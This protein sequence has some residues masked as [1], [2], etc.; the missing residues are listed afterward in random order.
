MVSLSAGVVE[1]AHVTPET[2]TILIRVLGEHE[3]YPTL[4]A[5]KVMLTHRIQPFV[6]HTAT[7]GTILSLQ[8][9]LEWD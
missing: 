9:T 7:T 3:G 1:R 4:V 8:I 2:S 5:I 6:T